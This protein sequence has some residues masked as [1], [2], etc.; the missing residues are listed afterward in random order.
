MTPRF[1]FRV[2]GERLADEREIVE[3]RAAFARDEEPRTDIYFVVPGR[4][5]ASLKLRGGKLDLKVL[6]NEENGLELWEPAAQAEFPVAPEILRARFLDPAGVRLDL[7]DAPVERDLLLTRARLAPLTRTVRVE[8][9]RHSLR[10]D[11]VAVEFTRLSVD[12]TPAETVAI[13]EVDRKRA[14]A[15]VEALRLSDR[16]NRSYQRFLVDRLFT[17]PGPGDAGM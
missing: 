1:E 4:V 6:R 2:F 5:D 7:P 16:R 9:H 12:G 10:L 17:P 11:D 14:L 3:R 15:A 8:K 13:E